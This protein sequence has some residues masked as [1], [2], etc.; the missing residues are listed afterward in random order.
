MFASVAEIR[1]TSEFFVS[2]IFGMA[3][4]RRRNQ[5]RR[6]QTMNALKSLSCRMSKI[7]LSLAV[8]AAFLSL[9]TGCH[10][11]EASD[12]VYGT[13]GGNARMIDGRLYP[14]A[15]VPVFNDGVPTAGSSA[16][17]VKPQNINLSDLQGAAL[18]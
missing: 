10:D 1:S 18:E 14:I 13:L 5:Q 7:M 17:G 9:G 2:G 8:A 3:Q 12:M 16:F 15:S 6:S 11:R 4:N